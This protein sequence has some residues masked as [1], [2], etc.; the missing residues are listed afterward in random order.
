[1]IRYKYSPILKYV[2]FFIIFTIII[3]MNNE[4]TQKNVIKIGI[5]SVALYILLDNVFIENHDNLLILN[6]ENQT[7]EQYFDKIEEKFELDD[8]EIEILDT[9]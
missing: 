2:L 8:K 6:V 4:I 7:P 3:I 9:I 1:M 5:L